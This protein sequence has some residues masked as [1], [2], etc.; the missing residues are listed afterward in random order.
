MSDAIVIIATPSASGRFEIEARVKPPQFVAS[1]AGARQ[2]GKL[3]VDWQSM[4]AL[5]MAPYAAGKIMDEFG[6][7]IAEALSSRLP[8]ATIAKM[9]KEDDGYKNLAEQVVEAITHVVAAGG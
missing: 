3:E 9:L 6:P 1:A 5:F 2:I 8:A 7:A 4:L